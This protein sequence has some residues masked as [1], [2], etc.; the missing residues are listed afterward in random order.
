M[1][2]TNYVRLLGRITQDLELK[3]PREG[4]T[5][6]DI[7]FVTNS[8]YKDKNGDK[9]TVTD[10]HSL[11]AKNKTAETIYKYAKKGHPLL[12]EGILKTQSWEQPD[13]T[14]RYKT[15]VEVTSVDFLKWYGEKKEES[16]TSDDVSISETPF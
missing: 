8:Y 12:V 13:G 7:S 5:V 10:Y 2:Q 4:F 3:T 11:S 1:I 16:N 9:Q 6:L 14:K 15:Y